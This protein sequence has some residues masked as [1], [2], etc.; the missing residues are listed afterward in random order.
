MSDYYEQVTVEPFIP[1]QQVSDLERTLLEG[2]GFDCE[3][4]Q[5]ENGGSLLYFFTEDGIRSACWLEDIPDLDNDDSELAVSLR[6]W[7]KQAER[8]AAWDGFEILSEVI[9]WRDLFQGILRKPQGLGEETIDEIVIQAA[10]WCSKASPG[11]PGGWVAR[12]TRQAVQE[13]GVYSLLEQFRR[14]TPVPDSFIN[15]LVAQGID[16]FQLDEE[17]HD[18]KSREVSVI[19]NGGLQT[20]VAYLLAQGVTTSHLCNLLGVAPFEAEGPING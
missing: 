19:N 15:Y 16:P 9:D 5:D 14:E 8:I 17:V 18:L 4:L 3:T 13:G 12:I 2:F 20:Q 11:A 7:A 6:P 10:C 1:A